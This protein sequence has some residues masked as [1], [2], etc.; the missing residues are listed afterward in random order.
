MRLIKQVAEFLA[1]IAGH[2]KRREYDAA[3]GEAN[4]AWTDVLDI[5]RE[6]VDRLDGPTLASMLRDPDKMRFAAQLLIEEAKAYA[7]KKDPMTAAMCYRHAFGLYLE[8]R[9]LAPTDAD[10][11][12]LFELSR[13]VPPGQIDPRYRE[14]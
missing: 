10:D 1:R 6:L 13:V 5:P 2:T 14:S 9:A 7:G 3:I 11:A 4:R 8:A 12:A